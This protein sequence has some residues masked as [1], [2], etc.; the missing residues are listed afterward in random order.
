M[1]RIA[2]HATELL[3]DGQ[4]STVEALLARLGDLPEHH[5]RSA[6]T[7]G[8]MDFSTGRFTSAR[9]Y[10]EVARADITHVMGHGDQP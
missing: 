3:N 4:F 7:K 1:G 9:H 2:I 5:S 6:G 8:W 10:Y